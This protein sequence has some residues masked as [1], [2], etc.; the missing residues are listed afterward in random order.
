MT[1]RIKTEWSFSAL[2]FELRKLSVLYRLTCVPVGFEPTTA[3]L[4][5]DNPL[6]TTRIGVLEGFEPSTCW[7]WGTSPLASRFCH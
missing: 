4:Q 6:P 1:L 7:F 2:P 3:R 5:D